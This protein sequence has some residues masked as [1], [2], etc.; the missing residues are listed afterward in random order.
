MLGIELDGYSHSIETIYEKDRKKESKLLEL[1]IKIL[2]FDDTE[3][4]DDI[5]NVL[6]TIVGYIDKFEETHP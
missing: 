3:V 4:L 6:L 1:D 5:D 2:R